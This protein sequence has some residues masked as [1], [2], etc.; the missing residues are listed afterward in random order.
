MQPFDCQM[1]KMKNCWCCIDAHFLDG[2]TSVSC[3]IGTIT[4]TNSF[5]LEW[6]D[7]AV[8]WLLNLKDWKSLT[9]HWHWFI[10]LGNDKQSSYTRSLYAT[11]RI[12]VIDVQYCV[13]NY[14]CLHPE[15]LWPLDFWSPSIHVMWV[16][17][18]VA[19]SHSCA[20]GRQL[21]ACRSYH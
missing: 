5:T 13:S 6:R 14:C 15:A 1:C 12:V 20:F 16:S 8:L 10:R 11:N 4:L 18:D 21:T 2:A 19:Q 7:N 9:L 3:A 17:D